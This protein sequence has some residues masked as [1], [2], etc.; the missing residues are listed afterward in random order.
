VLQ[1]QADDIWTSTRWQYHRGRYEITAKRRARGAQGEF[2]WTRQAI[3]KIIRDTA[4]KGE[5]VIYAGQNEYYEALD[6]ATGLWVR[7]RRVT[8]RDEHDPAR[9][10]V[11]VP[12]LVST[13]LW[14]RANAMLDQAGK[15]SPRSRVEHEDALLA[16]G[17]VVCGHCDTGMVV[18][19]RKPGAGSD[20]GSAWYVC[21]RRRAARDIVSRVCPAGGAWA[22]VAPLDAWAWAEF[23][24]HIEQPERLEALLRRA[25]GQTSEDRRTTISD[26]AVLD[27]QVRDLAQRQANVEA[28]MELVSDPDA[29]LGVARRL[30][31][32][33]AELR[34]ARERRAAVLAADDERTA[35][36]AE[37]EEAVNWARSWAEGDLDALTYREK[38]LLLFAFGA[39]VTVKRGAR[40][41]QPWAELSLDWEGLEREL[42]HAAAQAV[43]A[44]QASDGNGN[45]NCDPAYSLAEK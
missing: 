32:I 1:L 18:I 12:A 16:R 10:V 43:Q 44:G 7:R 45:G 8:R 30:D 23:K 11:E 22:K 35:G 6:P 5:H 33:T 2:R 28:Q 38:R 3:S 31:G 9:V 36:L 4:Y 25:Q 40:K 27:A 41:G 42:A 17:H 34:G 20:E 37:L 26:L 21:R 13:D 19:R 24:R 39:K 29:R 14:A 15:D